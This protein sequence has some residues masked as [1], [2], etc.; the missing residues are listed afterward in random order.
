MIPVMVNLQGNTSYSFKGKTIKGVVP[1]EEIGIN[2]TSSGKQVRLTEPFHNTTVSM[3]ADG[4]SGISITVNDVSVYV[5]ANY[6]NEKVRPL[7]CVTFCGTTAC[8][9]RGACV[10]CGATTVCC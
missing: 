3:D 10:T 5:L 2:V 6:S 4:I 1:G 9:G 7:C 8:G